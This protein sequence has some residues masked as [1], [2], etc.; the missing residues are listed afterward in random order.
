MKRKNIFLLFVLTLAI[1]VKS[2]NVSSP[3]ETFV[4]CT[5]GSPSSFNP[6]QV[7]D[8]TSL[9][10]S[11]NNVYNTLVTFK[12]GSTEI[13]PALATHWE[14][15]EDGLRYQFFLRRNVSFHHQGTFAPKRFF[16]ADDVLF[17]FNRQ[18]DQDHPFHN[19][20]TA[21]YEYFSSMEMGE[22]V[23][24]LNKVDD[25]TIE[26]ILNRPEA[27]FLANLGMGFMSILSREYA[28]YLQA[29]NQMEKIDWEPV[30][31][32]PFR[33][34]RYQQ[35]HLIRYE[36]FEEA[37]QGRPRIDRLVFSI[38]PDAS[39]RYQ[40]LKAGE[41]H[42]IIEPAPSDLSS[43]AVDPTITLLSAAGLN[44]GYLAFNT[45]RAPFDNPKVRRA[46]LMSLN[47]PAYMEAIYH[48]HAI[49][50]HNPLPPQMWPNVDHEEDLSSEW[51]SFDPDAAKKLLAEAGFPNGF[52]TEIW[53]L[54]VSRPYNPNGR[55]M[56]EMMQAD[57]QRVGIRVRLIS[58]DWPTYLQRSRNGEHQLLQLGWTGD[59]GDPDNFLSVLLGCHSV[60][61][62][63]NVARWCHE[64]FDQ[65][66]TRAK[67]ITDRKQR[68]EL[69]LKAQEIFRRELPWAPIAH[70]MV[71]R[72]Y[73]ANVGGVV[74]DPLGG[75]KF[76]EV[77]FR[78]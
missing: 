30:G 7:T 47:R 3:L 58:Y 74:I 40:K 63:S 29:N 60:Q 19:V 20:G 12:R 48:G 68:S 76:G 43:L 62:G 45:E 39:V 34:Y 67:K 23:K 66:V 28:D 46:V 17:S 18:K 6:Q 31:T 44:T 61:T 9:N 65:L 15:S 16:N 51:V 53:T 54:P 2:C 42:F 69:Y 77:Y 1:Q 21:R 50:A 41:C 32:G 24:E 37:W 75:D 59:N 70:S 5:E 52:E 71:F 14:I 8:G 78:P 38:T 35:D 73:A 13:I 33:F 27:P 10:A 36:A 11:A 55:R 49:V 25:Y 22:L 57:L 56:G 26:F 72:A 64:E 4:Y